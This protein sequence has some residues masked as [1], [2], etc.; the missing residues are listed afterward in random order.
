MR[1]QTIH[2][3]LSITPHRP[4]R[5]F[6]TAV[7]RYAMRNSR[8][9]K[10]VSVPT[11]LFG[12][13]ARAVAAVAASKTPDPVGS[14]PVVAR[15]ERLL[16]LPRWVTSNRAR[17]AGVPVVELTTS[18]GTA[19]TTVLHLHVGAYT[20]GSSRTAYSLAKIL[21]RATTKIVSVEYRLAPE[22][23][24]P[25][26][27]DDAFAV[28]SHLVAESSV[29][30]VVV[31]GESSGGGLALSL[32][33]RAR[34]EALPL[35]H[36]LALSFPWADLTLSGASVATNDGEDLLTARGL[37]ASAAAYSAGHDG[38]DPYVSAVFGHFSEFPRTLILVGQRDLLLDDSR[39]VAARMRA[40]GVDVELREWS[41]ST[42]G[43]TGLPT[44]EGRDAAGALDD[45][46]V[47]RLNELN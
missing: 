26:A 39:R 27:L 33:L 37:V 1:N 24:Y 18:T 23:P 38:S 3:F 40:A 30:R 2:V 21:S 16:R 31:E 20:S 25:A 13:V 10:K 6:A 35:P 46:I 7:R 14:R 44:T 32:L 29:D 15:F 41:G 5:T 11:V 28:Y 4:H 36:A 43:F 45:F 22:H 9:V 8:R 17:I 34:D 12:V 42:H 47:D 19:S